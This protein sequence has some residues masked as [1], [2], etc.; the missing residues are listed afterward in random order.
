MCPDAQPKHF[1][2][3][4]CFKMWTFS[5]GAQSFHL[6]KWKVLDTDG[7]WWFQTMWIDSMPQNCPLKTGPK[8]PFH[9]MHIWSQKKGDKWTILLNLTSLII[10]L[11]RAYQGERLALLK[12]KWDFREFSSGL[13]NETRHFYCRSPCSILDCGSKIPKAKRVHTHTHTHKGGGREILLQKQNSKYS[14][15]F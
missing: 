14:S 12:S 6:G 13:V 1:W 3:K 10:F 9:V 7:E 15:L 11:I 4:S 8:T 5:L 2:N